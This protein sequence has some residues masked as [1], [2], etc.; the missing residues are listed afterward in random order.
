MSR[1]TLK[2]K[3]FRESTL[4]SFRWSRP[5]FY[6]WFTCKSKK[7]AS[8]VACI[9]NDYDWLFALMTAV[10]SQKSN[11]NK[12]FLPISKPKG[13]Q[14]ELGVLCNCIISAFLSLRW[15]RGGVAEPILSDLRGIESNWARCS[16]LYIISIKTEYYKIRNGDEGTHT[17]SVKQSLLC[18][19]EHGGLAKYYDWS[20]R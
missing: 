7:I 15:T 19:I 10:G 11:R 4:C 14:I 5:Y 2:L 12:R 8:Q 6:F 16:I 20:Y 18:K 17:N 9:K 1:L 3:S 13:L